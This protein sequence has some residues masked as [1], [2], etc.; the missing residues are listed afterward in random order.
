MNQI[1]LSALIK[2]NAYVPSIVVKRRSW[3]WS[4]ERHCNTF[5]AVGAY[6]MPLFLFLPFT[7]IFI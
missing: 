5:T 4:K 7:R 2:N 1:M 6:V 3:L